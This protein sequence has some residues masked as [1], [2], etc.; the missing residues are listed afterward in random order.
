LIPDKE[1]ASPVS[2][3]AKRK[4]EQMLAVLTNQAATA[5]D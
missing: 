2:L 3:A 5:V 4:D 1:G